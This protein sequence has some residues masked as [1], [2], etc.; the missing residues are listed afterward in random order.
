MTAVIALHG[1]G[2]TIPQG[3]RP[4]EPVVRD[5]TKIVYETAKFFNKY[6][7][8]TEVIISGGTV[9][10]GVLEVDAMCEKM[11]Q[12]FPDLYNIVDVILEKESRNTKENVIETFKYARKIGAEILCPSSSKD[13]ISRVARDWAYEKKEGDPM[14]AFVPSQ[15][16]YSIRG[17]PPII[18]E[19]PFWGYD[20][21]S[22]VFKIQNKDEK[23]NR[24]NF[25]KDFLALLKEYVQ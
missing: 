24:E 5:R 16:P 12:D 3:F 22:D 18:A 21:L 6:G 19:S 2:Q 8:E 17:A 9:T 13:H 25:K 14:L 20:L 7:I 1:Y 4:W 10:N 15:E 11:N 23:I